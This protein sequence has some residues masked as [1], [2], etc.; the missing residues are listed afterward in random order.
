MMDPQIF[1]I[2]ERLHRHLR[3][4]A[5]KQQELKSW[6]EAVEKY[7][8]VALETL[9]ERHHMLQMY[10]QAEEVLTKAKNDVEMADKNLASQNVGAY[11][12][13]EAKL[14]AAEEREKV[15]EEST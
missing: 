9:R 10:K 15:M 14:R 1:T 7:K 6:D 5:K 2:K 3:S 4:L 13:A 8:K 11:K 12:F